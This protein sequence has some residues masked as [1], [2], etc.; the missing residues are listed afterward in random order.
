MMTGMVCQS[1][2]LANSW[3]WVARN[4]AALAMAATCASLLAFVTVMLAK[5]VRICLNIF[6]DTHPPL[7][8]MPLDFLPLRGEVVRFRSFDGISLRGMHLPTPVR[9]DYRGAIVFCHEFSSDMYSSARYI[10]P[11]VEAGFDVFTFDFRGHGDSSS[12]R[13]YQ[14]L[15]WPSDKE[16]EDVLG[17]CAYVEASLEAE[18]KSPKIGLFGVSRGAGAGLLAAATD[19]NIQA[20]VTDGAFSTIETLVALMKRWAGIFAR[21]RLVYKNHPE[22]FW[23]LLAWLLMRAAQPRLGRRFPSV[24]KALR[25][26]QP[27][28]ILMIHGQRDS[29][30]RMEHAWQ[31]YEAAPRPKKLWIVPQA[32]HNQSVA[33]APD[34]Y[35]RRTVEFFRRHLAN[36]QPENESADEVA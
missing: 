24:L 12:G 13:H 32:K 15:Q 14:P 30:I 17:A 6:V 1:I 26:M 11:L 33:V 28:P 35:A 9:E 3:S 5:Y 10:R 21:V 25:E 27:R 7:S 18:G 34:Q 29:Y 4:W 22:A 2:L 16:M 8:M 23:R 36:E 20:I 19:P 31:L